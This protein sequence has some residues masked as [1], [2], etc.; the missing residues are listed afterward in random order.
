MKTSTERTKDILAR[1]D[2]E[3]ARRKKRITLTS[4]LAAGLSLVLAFNLVLFIPYN[5]AM[6]DLSAYKDS[7]YYS[8]MQQINEL[9]YRPPRYKNNFEAWFGDL[10]SGKGD[11][12]AEAPGNAGDDSA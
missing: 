6:P 9:T 1:A 12:M 5:T 11:D 8:L 7:E 4:V 3:K 10:F 2:A